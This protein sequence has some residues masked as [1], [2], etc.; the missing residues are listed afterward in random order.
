MFEAGGLLRGAGGGVV[1]DEWLDRLF[2][3]VC[4]LRALASFSPLT[5]DSDANR[6]NGTYKMECFMCRSKDECQR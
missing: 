3:M 6:L 2:A 1:A 5:G 4:A